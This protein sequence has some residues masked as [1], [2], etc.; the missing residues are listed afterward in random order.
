MT[1]PHER[2]AR[3][4]WRIIG[5]AAVLIAVTTGLR[6]SLGL[7]LRPIAATGAGIAFVS[8][9]LAVGQFFWGA[10][11]PVFGILADRLGAARV[12]V[13]GGLLLASGF[14]LTPWSSSPLGLLVTLGIVSAI[15]AGAASFAILIGAVAVRV[16]SQHQ[17]I[18]SGVINSGASLGQFLIAPLAQFLIAAASWQSAMWLLA[19]LAAASTLLAGSATGGRAPNHSHTTVTMDSLPIAEMLRTAFRDRSYW[20]LHASLFACGFHI[21][22]LSTHLPNEVSI[23]GLPASAAANALAVI[24]LLNVAG[25]LTFGWLGSRRSFKSLL[26]A[27]Y[28]ARVVA[29]G[30]YLL[31]PKTLATLYMFSAVIGF[32]WLATIPSTAGLL[33]KLFGA[34]HL[35]T[36]LG[37][38]MLTHQIGAFFGA[39]LGGLAVGLTGNYTTI[40]LADM[41]LAL[42]AASANIPI[43]E[44]HPREP[45]P[46]P[47]R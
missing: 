38:T 14:A 42:V 36:L 25:S 12:L 15:G 43:R 10:S 34:R 31:A 21:A 35:S 41:A 46:A 5:A 26:A 3:I 4:P 33:G 7:F 44:P 16:S 37:M 8:F 28:C 18:A 45:A 27:L 23:C 29:I 13:I 22:F 11:Q 17:S 24:G 32:T 9:A 6:Q 19:A 2:G 20:C 39:W 1:N 40:W 30:A 47:A